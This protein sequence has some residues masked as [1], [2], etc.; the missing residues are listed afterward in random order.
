MDAAKAKYPICAEQYLK[1]NCHRLIHELKSYKYVHPTTNN[2]FHDGDK[3]SCLQVVSSSDYV[4]HPLT[5]DLFK[6]ALVSLLR[7]KL[8]SGVFMSA[9]SVILQTPHLFVC[10]SQENNKPSSSLPVLPFK[11]LAHMGTVFREQ[12]TRVSFLSFQPCVHM[13]TVFK[14][15]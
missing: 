9:H 13:D 12:Y 10:L 8:H 6:G 15:P 5:H 2:H 11:S 1:A 7:A 14:E 3:V 4:Q